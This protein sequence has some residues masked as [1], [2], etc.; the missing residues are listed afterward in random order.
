MDRARGTWKLCHRAGTAALIAA[1]VAGT[2]A[3]ETLILKDG[4]T[5]DGKLGK[6][7]GMAENPL[8]MAAAGA[9][10]I[11]RPIVFV[12]DDLRRTFL[13]MF[14]VSEVQQQNAGAVERIRIPQQVAETGARLGRIG[15]IVSI[16]PFDE[17]GRRI[18]AMM[19]DKGQI[20]VIQGITEI[21]PVWTKVEGLTGKRPFVWDMRIA[22]SSIPR[23]TLNKVLAKR[24]DPTKADHRLRLV[25]LFVQG[26]RYQDAQKELE[27]IIKDFPE[28]QELQAEVRALQQINSRRIIDEINMR[29]KAGQHQLAYNL[30]NNFPTANVAGET[31]VQVKQIL[32]EYTETQTQG[33]KIQ[34]LLKAHLEAVKDSALRKR[35][36]V[37]YQELVRELNIN[38]ID[39]MADYL[40]LSDDPQLSAEEK[41]ALA[42]SGWL[43][44]GN[45]AT[46]NLAV[47]LSLFEVRNLVHTYMNKP[48]LVDRTNILTALRGQ[49]GSTPKMVAQLLSKMKPP[50]DTPPAA[51]D[52]PGFHQLSIPGTDQEPDVT[53]YV[54][55]PPE[56]DP[57]RRYPAIVTLDGAGTTA[58]QQVDWWAGAVE[59]RGNRLGQ[60]TR[61][62][63]IVVAVD[64]AKEE[65]K[66]YEFSAREHAAVL[67]SLRDACRRFAIDT[68]RV[69]LS[70][71]S[72]GGDAVWDMA[73]AHPDLWAGVIP[74]VA[75]ADK[76]CALYW[77]N[78]AEVPFYFLGGEMDGDKTLKN[79]RDLDRYMLHR[80]DVSVTE[81]LGRG[82]EHFFDDIQRIFDWMSRRERNFFP[83]KFNV[84]TMRPWDNFFWWLE[85]REFPAKGIVVNW[86]P[87]PG[88]RAVKVEASINANNIY[89]TTGA[90]KVTVWLSP[91]LVDFEKP[92]RVTLNS[93]RIGTKSLNVEASL[94]VLLED[95]RTR[96][97]RQHPFWA[98]IE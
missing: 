79:A 11:V 62:G 17:F 23:E 70:G 13:P 51:P 80:Y 8:A 85:L 47:A 21:T 44:G 9:G 58:E 87:A 63:Y 53:Y 91:Q 57:Y 46:T 36:D 1:L 75:T 65:Q 52:K 12:D 33:R 27:A 7:G 43:L 66:A 93:Q 38:T 81:Y 15:P 56:Y 74:I 3:A 5:L 18:F 78:A 72:M 55:L 77:E 32:G 25:R 20:D 29:R 30:L 24:I 67:G 26:E 64:W 68:D 86:P 37:V 31:L 42:V 54:Q 40:R 97:D 82:H 2:A 84:A 34:E 89:I 95:V 71:H 48:L 28:K 59:A 50:L 92:T 39:R 41:F 94:Q 60:A 22:T 16:T 49:E 69:F 96:G 45:E 76:F 61:R 73:L 90:D 14:Y 6:V 88:A 4:R 19:T 10:P 83:K 35:C 98:K